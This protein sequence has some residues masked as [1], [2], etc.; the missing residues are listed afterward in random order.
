MSQKETRAEIFKRALTAAT[1]SMSRARDVEVTF[2]AD[3][4]GGNGPRVN[5]PPP[6]RDLSPIEA[7]RLRGAGDAAALRLAHHDSVAHNALKPDGPRAR[8]LYD[9]AEDAR[10]QAIGARAMLGV[11]DNLA[12]ALAEKCEKRGYGRAED[13]QQAPLADALAM[14]LRERLTGRAPPAAAAGLMKVWRAEIEEKAAGSLDALEASL[15]DQRAFAM[16][17]RAVMRD[18]DLGEEIGDEPSDSGD[19]EDAPEMDSEPPEDEDQDQDNQDEAD[20]GQDMESMT[21]ERG[22]AEPSDDL[23]ESDAEGEEGEESDQEPED[24]ARPIRP[25]WRR[26]D[27]NLSRY[28]IFTHAHDE[29]VDAED[30]CD[31]EE[32]S[33]LRSYLDMQLQAL[34][35]AVGRLANKLQRRLLAKQSRNWTFDLEEGVLDVSRL[36]RVITDPMA[37]LSF[38]ME[39]DT[40]FRDTVVTLLLDN[41]GSMRGRPIMVAAL[42][43]DILT[44]TLERCGVKVEV[45]GF[46]TRAWKGG[47]SREDWTK[48]GKPAMPG[49]LNDIRHIIYKAA[50]APWRRSKRNL[51]LMM[52]E[53]LLKENIDG[54]AL[55]WAHDRLL[56]R[57]E[58][59]RILMVISDGAPV[60][61]STLSAN[62]GN[63]L[64][65]H[66]RDAIDLIENRSPVELLAIGI[67]HDV[68]RYYKRAV[69]IVDADQLGGAMTEKLAELC[70]ETPPPSSRRRGDPA[71]SGRHPSGGDDLKRARARDGAA[72]RDVR[73]KA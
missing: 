13:R 61:D 64:E 47:Q 40:K 33:R 58:Q 59:R 11:G 46:T 71:L 41:S 52:R 51:G 27:D 68:T 67:G 8:A 42:C 31:A 45:L 1:R 57:P 50:D 4:G 7:A 28:K 60:D 26:E 18:L 5:L 19:S 21:Q 12:A 38:K 72:S 54:E 24:G 25:N 36:P 56:G 70:D 20:S 62:S 22:E 65:R 39:D 2:T 3:A 10:V 34:Q 29:I 32:L 15:E 35:G 30:L 43:A 66:L 44:R 73:R 16:K 17:L 49:R 6:P 14:V 23:I 37:P 55:L 69:T 53:G 48:A 63:Y 9:A